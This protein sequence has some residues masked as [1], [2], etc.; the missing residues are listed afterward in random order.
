VSPLEDINIMSASLMIMVN[1]L[2]SI[3]LSTNMRFFR[4]LE[5][6]KPLLNVCLTRKFL[7][8]KLDG[9]GNIKD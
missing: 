9:K 4:S 2:G 6:S 1:S 5:N 3:C 8:Y 7:S